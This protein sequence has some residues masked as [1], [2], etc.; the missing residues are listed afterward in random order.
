M[1][2]KFHN[3][4]NF[5]RTPARNLNDPAF[6]DHEPATQDRYHPDLIS[7][8][9]TISIETMT[10]L[11][12]M[13]QA[14]AEHPSNMP[15]LVGMKKGP[16]GL[17]LL[18]GSSVKGMLRSAYEAVTNSRFGVFQTSKEPAGTTPEER[19]KLVHNRHLTHRP[20]TAKSVTDWVAISLG[21]GRALIRRLVRVPETLVDHIP[22]RSKVLALVK[23]YQLEHGA[24]L[25]EATHV[26]TD[27]ANITQIPEGQTLVS[28]VLRKTG[29]IA[30][31]T[32]T[33][34]KHE[35]IAPIN[36]RTQRGGAAPSSD[37][38]L[39]VDPAPVRLD[40]EV[41]QRWREVIADYQLGCPDDTRAV[42]MTTRGDDGAAVT[43]DCHVAP[44]RL[45]GDSPWRNFDLDTVAMAVLDRQGTVTKLVPAG[46]S[47]HAFTNTAQDLLHTSLW[48]VD[49]SNAASPADRLFGFVTTPD[50]PT[51]YRGSIL[52]GTPVCHN[53]RLMQRPGGSPVRLAILNSPKPSQFRFYTGKRDGDLLSKGYSE[54]QAFDSSS[55]SLRGRKMYLTHREFLAGGDAA[56]NYWSP[57]Q[58]NA[59]PVN[60]Q[61]REY[62][63]ALSVKE[64]KPSVRSNLLEWISPG[65]R[66][67]CRLDVINASTA[68]LAPLLWLL[69]QRDPGGDNAAPAML[70]I[71]GGKPLGFGAVRVSV[72][73]EETR[74]MTGE[75]LASARYSTLKQRKPEPNPELCPL[76]LAKRFDAMPGY[77]QDWLTMARGVTGPIHY[78]RTRPQPEIEGF[79]WFRN[80]QKPLA[81]HAL[82]KPGDM[83]E[84]LYS[85]GQA[86]DG[87]N[88]PPPQRR[89]GGQP[90]P[91]PRNGQRRGPD[92][93]GEG[94]GGRRRRR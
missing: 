39:G 54:G 9:I 34:K 51:S 52:T 22:D 81:G 3:P 47:R 27:Q 92:Q 67:T 56:N 50:E 8:H 26:A 59:N 53:D 57:A 25:F 42:P 91:G 29:T 44:W 7:G 86:W 71:G 61:Y 69:A 30:V 32:N 15:R 87:I 83:L 12:L 33:Y 58:V 49:S 16:D 88:A 85:D 76:A 93:R 18:Y 64:D 10:P 5:V 46:I 63:T 6:G 13:D 68:E 28:A 78:P 40:A 89:G 90:R 21:D 65:T 82:P 75:E 1:T 41:L 36:V 72:V 2:Y 80:N 70:K 66:F 45:P 94:R 19:K 73:A 60:G 35:I 48:P 84:A 38:L 37:E 55:S 4:Y 20:S 43:L 62:V 11:L 24:W 14:R 77:V 23:K 31:A 79:Q 17:P 74:L